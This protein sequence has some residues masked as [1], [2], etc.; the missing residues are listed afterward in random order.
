[1]DA[2]P[3]VIQGHHHGLVLGGADIVAG[4]LRR[5]GGG[6]AAGRLGVV[7]VEEHLR[8]EDRQLVGDVQG[9]EQ[10]PPLGA[11][12]PEPEPLVARLQPHDWLPLVVDRAVQ[13]LHGV[14]SRNL[15][16]LAGRGDS[17]QDRVFVH[18]ESS[19]Q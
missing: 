12:Q 14:E 10:H 15:V 17:A 11:G 13:V 6:E 16:Q 9:V 18:L 1:M 2:E 4:L 7:P 8:L 19:S 5:L 3:G